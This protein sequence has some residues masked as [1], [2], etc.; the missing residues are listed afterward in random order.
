[1]IPSK[2]QKWIENEV[3]PQRI[4]LSGS[5]NNIDLALE[6]ASILQ[7]TT[8]DKI[9]KGIHSDT[10][11]FRDK[12]KSFKIG[13]DSNDKEQGEHEHVRG[14]IRWA[15]QKPV[16]GQYR[17]VILE[18]LERLS[19]ESPHA[20]LKL[21][22]EP[23]LKTIFL[24]TTLNHHNKQLLDTILSRLTIVRIPPEE[25][26]FE[27]SDDIKMF[28]D[29]PNL[30][31][32]FQYIEDLDKESKNN[33]D[34][35]IDRTVFLAFLKQMIH[36]ARFLQSHQPHLELILESYNALKQNINPRLTLERLAVKITKKNKK[37]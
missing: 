35:K 8:K 32:K 36:H 25:I 14:L 12:G 11:V 21:I 13:I 1:M 22:E 27:I 20:C 2:I 31:S 16:E 26:D 15:H 34:K 3:F 24:F 10:V 29:S 18:N 19:N 5:N 28:L 37:E 17:I 4:L 6:I 9:E 7:K 33:A 23:P 30:I